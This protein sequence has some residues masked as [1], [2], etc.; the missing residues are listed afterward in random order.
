MVSE[1][2][3]IPVAF[4]LR[5]PLVTARKTLFRKRGFLLAIEH[6]GRKYVSEVSLLPAFG[7]EHFEHA[8]RILNGESMMMHSAPATVFGLDCIRHALEKKD[9]REI[10]VPITKLLPSGKNEDIIAAARQA[11]IESFDTVKLKVGFRS[12]EEDIALINTLA[13]DMPELVLRLDANLGWTPDDVKKL[14][15]ALPREAVEWIEDPCRLSMREWA[16]LQDQVGIPFACDEAFQE[17]E[18]LDYDGVPGFKTFVLK[19]ARMGAIRER[20]ALLVRMREEGIAI[21]LS[22]MFDSSVGLA[23]LAHLA[24]EWSLPGIAQG[25]GTLHLLKRDTFDQG[26]AVEAGHLIVP[27]L[28]SLAS[29]LRPEF[30]ESL[31]L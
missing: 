12:V 1:I 16:E 6:E 28:K 22:S 23:H 24:H 20:E 2:R 29:R 31:E 5:E 27:P 8:E 3:H 9:D 26:L 21:V 13:L 4:D 15:D 14:A 30:A 18:I 7:T 17:Q 11:M 10:R 25:L 19:P